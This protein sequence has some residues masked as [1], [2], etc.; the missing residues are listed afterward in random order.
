MRVRGPRGSKRSNYIAQAISTGSTVIV[1]K[2]G[3]RFER[4]GSPGEAS[5]PGTL[6]LSLPGSVRRKEPG[7][8]ASVDLECQWFSTS[9]YSTACSNVIAQPSAQAAAAFTGRRE[10][11]SC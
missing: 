3:K 6:P 9:A 8:S 5:H 7:L 4:R 2:N 10:P 1:P 11:Q